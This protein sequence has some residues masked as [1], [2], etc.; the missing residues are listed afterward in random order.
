MANGDTPDVDPVEDSTP[1]SGTAAQEGAERLLAGKYKDA[2]ELEKAYSSLE[3]KLGGLGTKASMFEKAWKDAG[4]LIDEEGNPELPAPDSRQNQA[5]GN[6]Q[7]YMELLKDQWYD[8]PVQAAAQFFGNM[9]TAVDQAEGNIE[10]ALAEREKDPMFREVQRAYRAELRKVKGYMSDPAAAKQIAQ[11]KY[12]A[13][14]GRAAREMMTKAASD[15]AARANAIKALNLESGGSG[16]GGDDEPL[17]DRADR[18][19]MK[20]AF[21]LDAEAQKRVEARLRAGAKKDE[22]ED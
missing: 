7:D 5:G 9:M 14:C 15:P 2:S 6:Q 20:D 13:V 10:E 17:L 19:F 4:G 8:N 21:G 11:E 16:S 18:L 3:S 1:G 12:D 22:E